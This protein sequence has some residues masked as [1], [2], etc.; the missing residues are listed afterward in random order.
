MN[1]LGSDDSHDSDA[2]Q[3]PLASQCWAPA[4]MCL[5]LSPCAKVEALSGVAREVRPK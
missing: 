3:E 2:S 5:E 1:V 4:S